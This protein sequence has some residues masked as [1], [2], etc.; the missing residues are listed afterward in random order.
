MYTIG[1]GSTQGLWAG[2]LSR[3]HT[4]SG[5]K[6]SNMCGYTYIH[7]IHMPEEEKGNVGF[8]YYEKQSHCTHCVLHT[9]MLGDILW[10]HC[11]GFIHT[12][13]HSVYLY[14]YLSKQNCLLPNP[15]S[16]GESAGATRLAD[17]WQWHQPN[18]NSCMQWS[19]LLWACRTHEMKEVRHN[20]EWWHQNIHPGF[21][22]QDSPCTSTPGSMHVLHDHCQTLV[23]V[24]APK[25]KLHKS[26]LSS[27]V[28]MVHK[29]G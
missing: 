22:P 27:V 20:I 1:Q 3:L 13:T 29:S 7:T 14:L 12:H 28:Y 16:G 25:R 9:Q 6:R 17:H 19:T 18:Y 5:M 4:R 11:A 2:M 15:N 8:N 24:L 21:W 26:L 23:G 10:N